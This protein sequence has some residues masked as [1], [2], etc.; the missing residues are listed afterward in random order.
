MAILISNYSFFEFTHYHT[1]FY[2]SVCNCVR[3]CMCNVYMFS[4][5]FFFLVFF[6]VGV[7]KGQCVK[8]C[9]T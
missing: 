5:L 3:V 1:F 7:H 8:N 6:L 4:F 2:L 9:N